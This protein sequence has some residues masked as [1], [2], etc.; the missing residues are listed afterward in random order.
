VI[1]TLIVIKVIDH[2]PKFNLCWQTLTLTCLDKWMSS[3]GA[4]RIQI[5]NKMSTK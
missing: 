2:D 3:M 4:L 1:N 5:P